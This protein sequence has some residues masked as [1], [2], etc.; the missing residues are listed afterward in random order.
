M[1][2][3]IALVLL[4]LIVGW[5]VWAWYW[6]P[7]PSDET[8]IRHFQENRDGFEKLIAAYRA[9]YPPDDCRPTSGCFWDNNAEIYE[10]KK[11]LN[12]NKIIVSGFDSAIWMLKDTYSAKPYRDLDDYLNAPASR[13][14]WLDR[15]H[16][17]KKYV[18]PKIV[19]VTLIPG[20]NRFNPDVK[21]SQGNAKNYRI[22]AGNSNDRGFSLRYGRISKAY[23]HIP[24]IPKVLPGKLLTQGTG[25]SKQYFDR[26]MDSLDRYPENWRRGEC[27]Y[28]QIETHWFLRLC[29]Y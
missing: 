12:I 7:L 20:K 18:Y 21:D 8:M 25:D 24:A 14:E 19:S 29:N 26:H 1:K 6:V 13:A 3:W 17:Y 23:F 11:S 27:V 9:Y 15:Y 4:A 22:D 2:K 10:L 28:R 5:Q 16:R